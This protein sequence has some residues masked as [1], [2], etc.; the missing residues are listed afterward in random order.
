MQTWLK[1]LDEVFNVEMDN[2]DCYKPISY[3]ELMQV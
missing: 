1:I 3:W 2:N